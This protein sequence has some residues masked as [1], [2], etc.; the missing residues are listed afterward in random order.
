MEKIKELWKE[1]ETNDVGQ[2][3]Y[4]MFKLF[5]LMIEEL[6]STKDIDLPPTKKRLTRLKD[7]EGYLYKISQDFLTSSSTMK[8]EEKLKKIKA[9]LESRKEQ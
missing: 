4:I 1:L 9:N 8:K 3:R 2:R 7:T 5:D 6:Y